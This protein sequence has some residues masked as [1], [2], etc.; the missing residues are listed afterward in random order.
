MKAYIIT[1]ARYEECYIKEWVKYNLEIG[2]DKIIINDNNPK[3]YPYNPK[4]IL[5]EYIDKGQVIIERYWDKYCD[6]INELPQEAAMYEVYTYLYHKYENEFDWVAKFDIDEFIEIPET[7][8]DIKQF[9]QQDKFNNALSIILPLETKTVK[10]EYKLYYTRLKNNRDRFTEYGDAHYML[11]SIIKKT[12]KLIEIDLHVAIFNSDK[13]DIKYMLPDGENGSLKLF[14]GEIVDDE[15][16]KNRQKQYF[17]YM[18]SLFNICYIKH[19]SDRS[20]EE[21]CYKIKKFQVDTGLVAWGKDWYIELKNQYPDM[22][23]HP[24]DL[25]KL[26][27]IDNINNIQED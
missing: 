19:Y 21:N 5:K 12:N 27:F 1:S 24:R 15:I 17:K 23:E 22:F 13:N 14:V 4:D 25:Y 7:H 11:K 9:L 8:N 3:D 16:Y 18:Q 26:Y 2:F 6:N 10:E 20:V